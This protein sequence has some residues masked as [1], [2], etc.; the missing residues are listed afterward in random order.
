[1]FIIPTSNTEVKF[2]EYTIVQ[3]DSLIQRYIHWYLYIQ[4]YDFTHYENIF[5]V[6]FGVLN[7][8]VLRCYLTFYFLFYYTCI[9]Y[10]FTSI[11]F[12]YVCKHFWDP[13]YVHRHLMV[14]HGLMMTLLSRN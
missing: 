12:F 5:V 4:S 3:S 6:S 13:K 7:C 2:T 1:M 11:S 8:A 14:Q 9:H 10:C